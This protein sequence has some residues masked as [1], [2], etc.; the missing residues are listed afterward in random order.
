MQR[1]FL[2]LVASAFSILAC[3]N[4]ST[5]RM[6]CQ[7]EAI[8]IPQD[9]SYLSTPLVIPTQL[10]EDKLN[11]AIKEDILDDD[12]FDNKNKKGKSDKLKMKVTRIGDIQVNWKDNVA[13]YHAPLLVLIEQEIVSRRVLPFP[14]SLAL[15]TEF[16]LRLIVETTVNIGEDWKLQPKTE[17]VSFEWLSEVKTLGGLIDIKKIVE[18]RLRRKMPEVLA[19]MDKTIRSTVN[20]DKTMAR[21]WR[22]IQKPMIINRKQEKV[23]LKINPIRFEMGTIT[24]EPGN[25]LI[26]T[27][28]S[29]TTETIVGNAPVYTVDSTLPPLVKR[30]VLPNHTYIYMLSEIPYTDINEIVDR[31]LAGKWFEMSG[32]RIKVKSAEVSGCGSNLVLHLR[33]RGD[34]RGDIY[35]QG[36]PHFE[37]DSQKI[38]FQ[39]FDFEIRTEEALV[40]SADWLLHSTFKEQMQNV[41]SIPLAEKI[42]K[43]P[44]A[45]MKGIE[46]GRVGP[47]M[48]FIIEQWDFRPQQI[49]VRPSDI[50]T[51]VIVNARV[52]VELEKL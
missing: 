21:I 46:D 45:I 1:Y 13:T 33:V 47:K 11:R 52:R 38:V 40:A 2:F 39:N 29:A 49:W 20:L 14:K 3:N 28:L 36:T 37:A 48:D 32:H 8:V 6:P 25:L 26:Q 30:Q 10:I 27:R 22:K 19:T 7:A 43:I 15:K 24:T 44:E 12:D 9:T 16:S 4:I 34:V 42:V 35:F 23:W 31:R 50:A 5:S 41:L 18:R 51:L 17:F